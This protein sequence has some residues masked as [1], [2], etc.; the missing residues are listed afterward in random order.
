MLRAAVKLYSRAGLHP[1]M[2]VVEAKMPI[3]ASSARHPTATQTL[4]P[5]AT[6]RFAVTKASGTNPVVLARYA[7]I[8]DSATLSV[9]LET[10][11]SPG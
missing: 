8:S 1:K 10:L 4:A 3:A 9:F 11:A 6:A 7:R 2:M 5:D